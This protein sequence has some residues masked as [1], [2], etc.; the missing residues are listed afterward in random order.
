MPRTHWVESAVEAVVAATTSHDLNS[1]SVQTCIR[2][3]ASH[4]GLGVFP[5]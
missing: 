1:M 2:P 4:P 5:H 3:R